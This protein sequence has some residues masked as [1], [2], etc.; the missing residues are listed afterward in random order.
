MPY[1]SYAGMS[2]RDVH[3][4]FTYLQNNVT[5]IDAG[6]TVETRLPFPFNVRSLMA[7]WNRLFARGR[8][9]DDVC[10][11]PG[12]VCRRAVSRRCHGALF[13]L[14]LTAQ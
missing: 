12:S 11:Q 13:R 4:L 14:P 10:D 2:D 1:T 7:G 8:P 5:A 6:P 9:V 3:A